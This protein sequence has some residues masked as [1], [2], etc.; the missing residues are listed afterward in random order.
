[1]TVSDPP[2]LDTEEREAAPSRGRPPYDTPAPWSGGNLG[3]V[4]RLLV[5]LGGAGA[6]VA[7]LV[8][9]LAPVVTSLPDAITAERADVEFDLSPG[10][11]RTQIFDR[12]GNLIGVLRSEVDREPVAFEDVPEAVRDTIVA[13]EDAAFWEHNGIDA[14]GIV[15]ALLSNVSTGGISQG[16]STITQQV[17][18]LRVVGDDPTVSRKVAE[19]FYAREL[20]EQFSK[21]QILGFY[22]NEV[23]FGNDAYGLQAAAEVYFGKNVGQLDTGDAALLAS[24]IRNPSRFDGFGNRE[25]VRLR[26]DLAVETLLEAGL[27]DEGEAEEY[28]TRPLPDRNL[29]PQQTDVNLQRNYYVDEVQSALYGLDELGG[30]FEEREESILRGGLRVYTTFDPTLQDHAE[31]AVAAVFPDGTGEFE[32]ALASVEPSTGAIRALV[33]GSGFSENEFN[34]ATQG[35]RQPG[36]SFKTYVLTAHVEDGGTP[37]NTISGTGPCS[38]KDGDRTY[39][40]Q[41]FGNSGGGVASIRSQTL[42]SSNCAFVRLGIYTG[43]GTVAEM[44]DAMIGRRS[45]Q[46]FVPFPSISLGAQEVTALEQASG[47]GVLANDGVLVPPYYVE[48]VEDR[49][50]NVVYE[51]EPA[52]RR[53]VSQ[54]TARIVTSVLE[55]NVR[56][57]T[58]TRARLASGQPAAGKTGTAQN[59]EDAWF[60]GYT[61]QLA[62]AVWMGHPKE[63]VPMRNVFGRGGVTGGSFPAM[64]WHEFTSRALEG[65]EIVPFPEAPPTG[66]GRFLFLEEDTCSVRFDI[67]DGDDAQQVVSRLPCGEVDLVDGGFTPKVDAMCQVDTDPS[68]EVTVTELIPCNEVVQRLTPPT[69]DDAHDRASRPTGSRRRQAEE[70]QEPRRLSH[71]PSGRAATVG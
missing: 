69:D 57:G 24:L 33:G 43:L 5:M 36:S 47:Y 22:L 10:A 67:G 1:M 2:R 19:A 65:A 34:L 14:K 18:K 52:A 16:G 55:G 71:P 60:V 61:P 25:L 54:D 4:W 12:D 50:G 30:T 7:V 8:V 13:V 44:A 35:K 3:P 70:A 26:R 48:R 53:V 58:G 17:V 62:T 63:K 32:V 40:V 6:L 9:L 39:R 15:R 27:I 42:R 66:R 56:S 41:N 37:N 49:E 28:M 68:P 59:F 46:R 51:R 29:S 45:E 31:A 21:E 11:Q 38:F 64:V 20:E 23:Y